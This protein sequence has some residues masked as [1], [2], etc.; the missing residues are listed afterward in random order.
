MNENKLTINTIEEALYF[1]PLKRSISSA[2][3][4]QLKKFNL[5]WCSKCRRTL[6][7][8]NF[9]NGQYHCKECGSKY[10]KKYNKENP[11][12]QKEYKL[13]NPE[14]WRTYQ[15]EYARRFRRENRDYY[16]ERDRKWRKK[17]GK[18]YRKMP[19]VKFRH[20]VSSMIARVKNGKCGIKTLRILA[21][22]S[23]KE[24]INLMT[25]KTNNK[26]WI[27]DGY[28]LDHIWQV[29]W[30][31]KSSI[32]HPKEVCLLINHHR[33]LRPLSKEENFMRSDVDFSPLNKK[34]FNLYSPYL[35]EDIKEKIKSYFSIS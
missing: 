19:H 12:Y 7:P 26:N 25:L 22:S 34:D 29:G 3:V 32:T 28:N 15:G 30:F 11:N 9:H 35:N 27:S 13:R 23:I 24:F 21:V 17:W 6:N 31:S 16:N 2:E 1:K 33:N 5:R 4:D 18:N 14:K 8:N 10:R 20:R